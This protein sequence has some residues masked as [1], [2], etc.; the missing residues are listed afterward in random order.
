MLG[1]DVHD[2]GRYYYDQESR[3]LEPGVV[4]TVEPGIVYL[5]ANEGYSG[6]VSGYWCAY[7]RRCALH[8]E[9]PTSFDE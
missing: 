7:R 4:M 6:T 1:I 8:S 9:W 3:A 2:V 5:A